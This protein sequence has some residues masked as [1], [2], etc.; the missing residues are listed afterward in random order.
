MMNGI[1]DYV[2]GLNH[3]GDNQTRFDNTI[4]VFGSSDRLWLYNMPT[5]QPAS[6]A[7]IEKCMHDQRV[8]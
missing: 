6:L 2:L 5:F 3:T 4:S 7:F 8:V 1:Y